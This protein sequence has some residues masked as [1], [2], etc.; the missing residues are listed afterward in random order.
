MKYDRV[1]ENRSIAPYCF[2]QR[3]AASIENGLHSTV[4][5]SAWKWFD[6]DN[7]IVLSF[8]EKKKEENT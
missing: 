6:S 8:C 4:K 2:V 3:N 1:N 5:L 7:G